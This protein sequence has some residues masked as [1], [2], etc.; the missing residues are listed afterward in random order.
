MVEL[1]WDRVEPLIEKVS[2]K[3]PEDVCIDVVKRELVN[4][5]SLLVIISRGTEIVAINVLEVNT[6]DTGV[7]ALYI[8]LTAGSEMELWLEEFLDIAR[9]IAKDYECTELRGL[10]VRDGWIRKLKPYGWEELFVTIR[11]KLGE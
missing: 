5:N 7:K 8:P 4:G 6:L 1:I 3:S 10:A 2:V 9:A 11:C